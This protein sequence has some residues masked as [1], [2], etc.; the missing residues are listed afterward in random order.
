MYKN[1]KGQSG[2]K[3]LWIIVDEQVNFSKQS[4]LQIHQEIVTGLN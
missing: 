3:D 2:W 1:Q 4:Q